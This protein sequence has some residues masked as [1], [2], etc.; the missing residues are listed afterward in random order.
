MTFTKIKKGYYEL[1]NTGHEV[2]KALQGQNAGKWF[3][4][5]FDG[6]ISKPFNTAKEAKQ[7]AELSAYGF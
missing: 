4:I 5:D 3:H 7:E 1:G 6:N 2:R